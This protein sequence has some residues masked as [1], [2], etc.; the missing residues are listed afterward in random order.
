LA[1]RSEANEPLLLLTA[2]RVISHRCLFVK[3]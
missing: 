2:I 3:A 1:S